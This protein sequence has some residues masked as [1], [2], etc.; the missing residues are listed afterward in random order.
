MSLTVTE[1]DISNFDTRKVTN[2]GSMFRLS[3]NL[4]TI[5]VGENWTTENAATDNMF[6]NC[7][8]KGVTLKPN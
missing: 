7:K 8:A 2:M 3:G 4:D 5:Y 1:L 6:K